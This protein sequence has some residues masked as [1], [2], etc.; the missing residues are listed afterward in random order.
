MLLNISTS[1][2]IFQ[3]NNIPIIHANSKTTYLDK[4]LDQLQKSNRFKD[5][6]IA[7]IIPYLIIKMV[8]IANG[9]KAKDFIFPEGLFVHHI[10]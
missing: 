6:P 2:V 3:K 1:S 8:T 4:I 9:K 7:D 5:E 10:F